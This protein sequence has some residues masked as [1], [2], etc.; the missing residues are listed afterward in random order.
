MLDI[1]APFRVKPYRDYKLDG[2]ANGAA[3]AAG[4]AN[5]DWYQTPVERKL[6]KQL[7]Q[8][9]DGPALR[10]TAIWIGLILLTGSLGV[11]FWGTWWAVPCFLVYGVLYTSAADSR[12]HE[13]GHGTAFKTAWMND[14]VYEFASFLMMRNPVVWRWS[15]ARHHTDT[16]IV[17]R[18][19]EIS[20]MRPTQ[21][22][23]LAIG[24]T[25]VTG[26]PQI[27][28]TLIGH[29]RGRLTPAE[30]DYVP[31]TEW[32]RAYTAARIHVA[33][34]VA[35]LLTCLAT[36]SIIPAL[37]IGLPR[38]YGIWLLILMGLP[39][40][41]GLQE[42]VLDHRLNAR[43]VLMSGPLRFIYSNMNYHVEHHMYPM[44][45]YHALPRLHE[46]VKHDCPAPCPSLVA[47]WQEIIPAY[48]RQRNDPT[49]FLVKQLPPGA[50]TARVA[51]LAA[52]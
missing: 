13:M 43:T 26:L 42:D 23:L 51:K 19:P 10:H 32:P 5:A 3:V 46:A 50:G 45:P 24:M 22:V 35:V 8:R 25:G 40:H 9:S 12:W 31:Q 21:L 1:L 47:A 11:A 44:V 37:L 34:Y 39:Q 20:N 38:A 33:I 6:L 29:A 52:E 28:A 2:P 17:G 7:M 4:L 16:I 30:Q 49:Y 18:D 14:V 15:H 27:L 48:L 36:W 41:A